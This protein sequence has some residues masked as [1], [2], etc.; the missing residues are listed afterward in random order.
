MSNAVLTSGRDHIGYG[1]LAIGW[2]FTVA[3]REDSH[4]SDWSSRSFVST[5]PVSGQPFAKLV[6]LCAV[7]LDVLHI[8]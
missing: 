4:T 1:A 5:G 8:A 6:H 3:G 2:S 7:G